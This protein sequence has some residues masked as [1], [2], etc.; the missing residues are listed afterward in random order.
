MLQ[1]A[2][3]PPSEEAAFCSAEAVEAGAALEEGEVLLVEAIIEEVEGV[4]EEE[5]EQVSSQEREDNPQEQ[6]QEHLRPGDL[7][8]GP[9]LEELRAFTALQVELRG[10]DCQSRKGPLAQKSAII[11]GNPGFWAKACKSRS[12]YTCQV[13]VEGARKGASSDKP[14]LEALEAW[15]ALQVE[16]SSVNQDPKAY[17]R[18]Q[19][20]GHQRRKRPLNQRTAGTRPSPDPLQ[21]GIFLFGTT[22]DFRNR[23]LI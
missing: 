4:A 11:Q 6:G 8:D 12:L 2:G 18:L 21:A 23:G 1:A 10:K 5:Q 16:L 7:S 19:R 20:K 22:P 9:T 14:P 3:G 13:E 17:L 15:A